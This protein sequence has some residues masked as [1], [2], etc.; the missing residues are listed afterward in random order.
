MLRSY[1]RRVPVGGLAIDPLTEPEVVAHVLRALDAGRGGWIVTPNVDILRQVARDPALRAELSAA[2]LAVADGAPL[3]WAARLAGRSLPA[4]VAGSDLVWSLSQGLAAAGR[5]IFVLG[6][7]PATDGAARAAATLA[8]AYEGLRIAGALSPPYGFDRPGAKLDKIRQTIR[9]AGP[10]MVYVGLG[11][12]RQERLIARLRSEHPRAWFLG[13]GAAVNFVAGD[14]QRAR[15]VLR[16]AGLEWLDRLARE[17]RRL[18]RRYL[19]EDAPFAAALLARSLHH[20]LTRKP[21]HRA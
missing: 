4:R 15:P 19:R 16:K 6:G 13:C 11:F 2:D 10:D 8:E 5:S 9:S 21:T 1:T 3:V 14:V 7:D 17:P 12:P 20:R 18:A